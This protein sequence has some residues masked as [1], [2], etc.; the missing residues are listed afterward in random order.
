[1]MYKFFDWYLDVWIATENNL[2]D[3]RW[4]FFQSTV[5]YTP[6]AKVEGIQIRTRSWWTSLLGMSDVVVKLS[7]MDEFTLVSAGSPNEIITYLQEM[8]SSPHHHEDEDDDREPFDILVDTLS[9]V[10]K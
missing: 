3:L 5:L 8:T 7:G 10:V 9:G 6:Y 1:M 2:V 4:K